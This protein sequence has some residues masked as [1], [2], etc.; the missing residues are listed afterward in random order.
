MAGHSANNQEK[1]E[2]AETASQLPRPL[3]EAEVL[4]S[5][6]VVS[7]VTEI[8][9]EISAPVTSITLTKFSMSSLSDKPVPTSK[10]SSA[11]DTASPKGTN[12]VEPKSVTETFSGP[13]AEEEPAPQTEIPVK[14]STVE[15]DPV[16]DFV[17]EPSPEEPIP[18]TESVFVSQVEFEGVTEVFEPAVADIVPATEAVWDPSI[19]EASAVTSISM[20]SSS[21]DL[22]QQS[23]THTESSVV[24]PTTGPT[25]E[26]APED[27]NPQTETL[28]ET[29]SPD[30]VDEEEQSGLSPHVL[31]P[32]TETPFEVSSM[33]PEP[34]TETLFK[35]L[36]KPLPTTESMDELSQDFTLENETDSEKP[37][38]PVAVPETEVPTTPL[39]D[40]ELSFDSHENIIPRTEI[41]LGGFAESLPKTKIRAEAPLE[42]HPEEIPQVE[43]V[44][45]LSPLDS[46]ATDNTHTGV[47]VEAETRITKDNDTETPE[48]LSHSL[49]I[50]GKEH[51]LPQDTLVESVDYEDLLA[52]VQQNVIPLIP[53]ATE[54]VDIA[55]LDVWKEALSHSET[56]SSEAEI[57]S[58]S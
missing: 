41:P 39:L 4:K 8:S 22:E 33:E 12:D 49:D 13:P 17:Y 58:V 36:Q 18:V 53:A 55:L 5:R 11:Y 2:S 48:A 44:T 7:E 10:T 1:T 16:T 42:T 45:N 26:I 46:I 47:T 27:L 52:E 20:K 43:V 30:P 3:P 28:F 25:V 56:N 9:S 57:G 29:A 6:V 34:V 37:R 38:A 23:K 51:I 21:T 54:E 50:V 40:T 35:S 19:E 14:T 15:A 31:I 24:I 32:V